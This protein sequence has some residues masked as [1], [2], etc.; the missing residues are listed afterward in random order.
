[1]AYSLGSQ[2]RQ[3]VLPGQYSP[4]LPSALGHHLFIYP[5]MFLDLV[6]EGIILL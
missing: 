5:A 4:L 1:M 2:R 3:E 6:D